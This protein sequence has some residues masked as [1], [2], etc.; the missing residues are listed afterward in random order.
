M[1]T[2]NLIY[3]NELSFP[4][5]DLLSGP[6]IFTS[7][8]NCIPMFSCTRQKEDQKVTFETLKF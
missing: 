6:L 1:K 5:G 2:Y 8:S 7:K 4:R 3:Q